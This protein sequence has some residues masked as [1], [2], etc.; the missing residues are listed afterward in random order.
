L[1][2]L[3]FRAALAKHLDDVLEY[4][5]VLA[6]QRSQLVDLVDRLVEA[7]MEV[8]VETWRVRRDS[9]ASLMVAQEVLVLELPQLAVDWLL[10]L[11]LERVLETFRPVLLYLSVVPVDLM[12]SG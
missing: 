3:R 4:L 11:A 7:H 8:I 10:S 1:E 12:L 2:A 5:R 6:L 9:Q